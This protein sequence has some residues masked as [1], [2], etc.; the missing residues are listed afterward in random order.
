MKKKDRKTEIKLERHKVRSELKK[1]VDPDE[2]SEEIIITAY[3]NKNGQGWEKVEI[4]YRK[5][6]I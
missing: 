1:V 4:L 2:D 3:Q 6:K 5:K